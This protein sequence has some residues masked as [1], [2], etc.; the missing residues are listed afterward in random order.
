[1]QRAAYSVVRLASAFISTRRLEVHDVGEL[2]RENSIIVR[3][4]GFF[5]RVTTSVMRV[6]WNP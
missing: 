4:Q 6:G 3:L 1:M 5:G 2:E